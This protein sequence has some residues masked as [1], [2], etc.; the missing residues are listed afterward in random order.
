MGHVIAVVT[1]T[2]GGRLYFLKGGVYYA[3]RICKRIDYD[4]SNELY[5]LF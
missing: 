4:E 3:E 5:G 2:D 1:T